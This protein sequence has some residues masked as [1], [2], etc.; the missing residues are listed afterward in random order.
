MENKSITCEKHK[1]ALSVKKAKGILEKVL[2]MIESD[3]YCPNVIQQIDAV[4][5]LLTSAK[6]TLLIGH[7]DHCLENRLKAN[8]PEAVEELIRI[9]DLN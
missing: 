1:A 9:F 7:L 4:R 8:K 2:L 6:K 5:G 3:T